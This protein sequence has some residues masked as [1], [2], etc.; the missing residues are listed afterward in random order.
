MRFGCWVADIDDVAVLAAS[1]Y[2]FC[3]L[4]AEVLAPAEPDAR[5]VPAL[6]RLEA[7]ALVPEV[8][9]RFFPPEVPL[10]GDLAAV[11]AH[12]RRVAQRAA[13]V[14]G[15]VVVLG[16]GPARTVPAGMNRGEARERLAGAVAAA[17]EECDRHGVIVALEPLNRG[18]CNILNTLEECREFRERFDLEGVY[19]TADLYHLEREHESS[20]EIVSAGAL[21]RHA[22]VAGG[23]RQ[24]PEIPG[25]DYAGFVK[26]LARARYD[27]RISAECDW[28]DLHE[29]APLALGFMRT[30]WAEA[31]H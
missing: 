17:Q 28:P 27:I 31:L 25:Y 20:A 19:L 5:A 3:E 6:R 2:E 18:E 7:L 9:N 23:G 11:R 22:Q 21:V 10:Y 15:E 8:F 24:S 29:Q 12:A 14:G 13:Q 16:S 4:S 26:A 1:G 30:G